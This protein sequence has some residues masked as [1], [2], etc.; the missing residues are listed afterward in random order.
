MEY[1]EICRTSEKLGV[2]RRSSK[3]ISQGRVIPPGE[4]PLV[5]SVLNW[6]VEYAQ[7]QTYEIRETSQMKGKVGYRHYNTGMK[8]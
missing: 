1:K 5:G 6:L 3:N 2:P 8:S 7:A 4:G